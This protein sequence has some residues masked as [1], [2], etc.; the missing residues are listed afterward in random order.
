MPLGLPSHLTP[1]NAASAF[2]SAMH[3][4]ALL[5]VVLAAV[6]ILGVQTDHPSVAV[7]PMLLA[8][9]PLL[10][11]IYLVEGGPGAPRAVAYLALG[12]LGVY[13][14]TFVGLSQGVV[15]PSSIALSTLKLA[16]VFVGAGCRAR[17]M[18]LWAIAG[19]LTAEGSALLAV[20]QA[21]STPTPDVTSLLVLACILVGIAIL[22]ANRRV[23]TRVQ[24]T[25]VRAAREERLAAA[26]QRLEMRAAAMLHDTVLGHLATLASSEP[27]P[28]RT[29]LAAQVSHDLTVLIGEEWLIEEDPV[30]RLP[31]Q[32]QLT[33]MH[34]AIE[35]SRAQGLRVAVSGDLGRVTALPAE[36]GTALALAAKQC[37]VNVVKHAGVYEAEL[38]VS[39]SGSVVTVMIVDAGRGFVVRNTAA[40]RLGL[41][42][43]VHRR[44]EA[45]GGSAKVWSEPGLG[46][47][48]LLAVPHAGSDRSDEAGRS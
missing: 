44:L 17:S 19:H 48:V 28:L 35:E 33:P 1:R 29:E 26:R 37:L 45:V 47:S 22:A 34:A 25:F 24:P 18:A 36:Q 31:E 9:L 41:R 20:A 12:G 8:T 3:A 10:V 14:G 27:G 42:Q 39:G 32:W 40:D 23:N 21:G 16:V 46:T 38:V 6:A 7:W 5:C 2:A 43:S 13:W 4:S 15:D 30:E 11:G